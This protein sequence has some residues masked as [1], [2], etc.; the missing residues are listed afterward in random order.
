MYDTNRQPQGVCRS[1]TIAS[2]SSY[3]I[4]LTDKHQVPITIVA[5]D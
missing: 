5:D 1:I 2:L 4:S 3:Q